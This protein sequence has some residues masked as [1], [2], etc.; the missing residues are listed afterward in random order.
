MPLEFKGDAI[1]LSGLTGTKLKCDVIGEYYRFWWNITSGGPSVEHRFPTAFVEL[2]AATGEVY[3]KDTDET[4]LGS[5]GHALDLKATGP[6]TS[7]LKVVLIEKDPGCYARLKEVMRKR[8]PSIDIAEA[9]KPLIKNSS[10]VCLFNLDF[11]VAIEQVKQIELGNSL[12]FF[13][14]L[15]SVTWQSVEKVAEGRM[16]NHYETGT[17]FMIFIFTSD[18][19][20]G[21]DELA[22]LPD[23]AD[24]TK[25]TEQQ[26]YTIS[27]ADSL[28]G[29]QN[30]RTAILTSEPT[31]V[32]ES[33]LIE[34]YRK[35]LH[36]WFRYVLPLPFNPK[37]NQLFHLILCSN[38]E[39]GVRM[40]KDYYSKKT[41]NP[42]YKPDNRAA[43]EKFKQLHRELT[44][45]LKGV[46]RPAEWKI[47]WK[48]ITQHEEGLCD[49]E[50]SDFA[51]IR[52]TPNEIQTCLEWLKE[53]G[54]LTE[55]D[56]RDAWN[57][58]VKQYVLNWPILISKLGIAPPLPLK[59][60]SS[61]MLRN[62]RG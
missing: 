26:W 31:T 7:N 34:L 56:I 58:E 24:E 36:K 1:S 27:E 38:Y 47:L 18:W 22:P 19:F 21:R 50:C 28:F 62:G 46:Q 48:I 4:V 13:D 29:D 30:W 12:F 41:G 37:K 25:W 52:V 2:D 23:Q 57:S 42:Q 32:R 3:I 10:N 6:S 20:L 16:G 17:E 59:P 14:P 45:R 53:E 60:L 9:E 55:S 54:Y 40:T 49:C 43:Y 44:Y 8:W 15:R 61:E 5:A 39:V 51:R 11:D 35:Q 33:K